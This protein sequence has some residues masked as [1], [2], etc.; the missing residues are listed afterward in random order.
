MYSKD[1]NKSLALKNAGFILYL[2]GLAIGPLLFG[3]RHTYA[4]SFVFMMFGVASIFFMAGSIKR[5]PKTGIHCL[6][7]P[8]F[9][10]GFVFLILLLYLFLQITPLPVGILKTLSPETAVV[11][12]KSFSPI[13]KNANEMKSHEWFPLS[14]YAY[15]IRMSAVRWVFYGLFFY[16][17]A[18]ALKSRKRIE[19]AIYVILG[20]GCFNALYGLIETYSGSEHVWWWKKTVGLGSITGTYDNRNHF[21]WLMEMGI[22]LAVALATALSEKKKKRKSGFRAK[23]GIRKKLLEALT[24]EQGVNKQILIFFSGIVMGVGLIFSASRG[25]ILS[26]VV[27][28]LLMGLLY[29][30]RRGYALKGVN[31]IILALFIS[32]YALNIGIKYPVQRFKSFHPDLKERI[33]VTRTTLDIFKDYPLF[34]VGV[35]N[36]QYIYPKYQEKEDKGLFREHAHNDWAQLLAEGGVIGFTLSLLG[37]CSYM[38]YMMRLWMKRKDPYAIGLGVAPLAAA[39]ALGIHSLF[40]YNL[41]RP[42]NFLILLATLAIGHSVLHIRRRK[43]GE[44]QV[45]KE[46]QI[47]LKR[48]GLVMVSLFLGLIVWSLAWTVKHGVAEGYCNTVMNFTL[49]RDQSPPLGEIR[50]AIQWDGGNAAY[51][52]K[53]ARELIRIRNER[54]NAHGSWRLTHGGRM[55]DE[56]CDKKRLQMEI[57][58]TLE[59]AIE[60]NP[61]RSE[62][63]LELGWEFVNMW[64]LEPKKHEKWLSAADVS[65]ERAAYFTGESNPYLYVLMGNYWIMRSKTVTFRSPDWETAWAKGKWHYR[66]NL[67]LETGF[68]RKRMVEEIKDNIRAH[69]SEDEYLKQVF[70]DE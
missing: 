38:I 14:S 17:F 41:H 26:S 23:R 4:Y 28:I 18:S 58:E 33:R 44:K 49:N 65:I 11:L 1:R 40:D 7:I 39:T 66:K 64:I 60:L 42:G 30:S 59:K 53:M 47:P 51:R 63:H 6:F 16:G 15:P 70:E 5:D 37:I 55:E 19:L 46:Y 48:K 69:Y 50:K 31:I 54:N 22:L 61:F 3:A 25:G 8:V 43:G 45:V 34:G 12:Q 35:G 52:W 36:F 13:V 57:I 56:L 32:V 9:R 21:A 24:R 62:Y 10:S 27:S 20:I 67:A 2:S 68:N 29:L